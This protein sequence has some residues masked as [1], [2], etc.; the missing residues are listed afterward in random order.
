MG[1]FAAV[2]TGKGTGAIATVQ[3]F[4][5]S[6]Q[7]M[8]EK[9][10]KPAGTIPA[11]FEPGKILLGTIADGGEIIDKVTVGCEEQNRFSINCHGNPLIVADIMQLLEKK[12]AKPLTSEQMRY[13]ALSGDKTLNTIAIEAKLAIP[14]AKTLEGTT[15]LTSQI[16]SGLSKTAHRWLNNI[17]SIPLDKI[18]ADT[19][20]I[21]SASQTA[22]LIIFGCKTILAGPANT[23]KS[24]LLNLLS[25]RD[26][27]IVTEVK[28]TTRDYVTATCQTGPLSVQLIDT[29]GLA[30]A[31]IKDFIDLASQKKTVELLGS[32]DL[33][34]LVLDISEPNSQLDEKLVGKLA[35]RKTLTCLNKTDLPARLDPAKLPQSLANTVK[36][37]ARF[38][39]G[40]EN[41]TRQIQKL[42]GIDGFD[43]HQPVCFTARQKALLE[44]LTTAKSTLQARP[45]ISR[46]LNSPLDV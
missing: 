12:G 25:G 18:A 44:Q 19:A 28:G 35:G 6:A 22:K 10:F 37:S 38:A 15:I 33:V 46:L 14:K 39:T 41:L 32:A 43:L 3:L 30:G 8:L 5:D 20:D 36:I 29:A 13:K 7:T 26:K 31:A 16:D 4:G 17:D 9:I 11:K 42:A 1:T 45:V 21:L 23:G 34:L 24:T 40:I 2:M 27:A